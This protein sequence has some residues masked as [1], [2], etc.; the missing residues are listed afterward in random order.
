VRCFT[1]TPGNKLAHRFFG[2]HIPEL[3]IGVLPNYRGNGIGAAILRRLIEE[4]RFQFPGIVLSVRRDNPAIRFYERL[5]FK[6]I[7][8]SQIVNRVGTESIHM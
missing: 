1:C 7:P 6:V 2:E 3:A 5:A 4:V 8:E